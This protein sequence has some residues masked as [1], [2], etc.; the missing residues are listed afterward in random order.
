VIIATSA[1]RVGIFVLAVGL[2]ILC[3]GDPKFIS[4]VVIMI[5]AALFCGLLPFHQACLRKLKQ[6]R[7]VSAFHASR[8]RRLDREFGAG[9]FQRC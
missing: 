8:L 2:A 3:L 9:H 7:A 6:A 1:L 4:M 5:P